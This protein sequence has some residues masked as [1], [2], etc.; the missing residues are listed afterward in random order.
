MNAHA[1]PVKLRETRVLTLAE[2]IAQGATPGFLLTVAN[3]LDRLGRAYNA[4]ASSMQA[5]DFEKREIRRYLREQAAE[6]F[7]N[8]ASLRRLSRD[9]RNALAIR[10]EKSVSK[11]AK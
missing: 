4:E 1:K 2:A 10:Q 7:I 9:V 5:P 3:S 8:A 6:N 11:S